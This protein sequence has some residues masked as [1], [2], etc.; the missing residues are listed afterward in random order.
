M[1]LVLLIVVAFPPQRTP[2]PPLLAP[3]HLHTALLRFRS[4]L[5][6][7]SRFHTPSISLHLK[8]TRAS[9]LTL[10]VHSTFHH[11]HAHSIYTYA[12]KFHTHCICSTLESIST[13]HILFTY[14]NIHFYPITMHQVLAP[15]YIA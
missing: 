14:F 6:R 9:S 8:K 12:L 7:I 13:C 10:R 15:N 4:L 11:T 3:I 2:P 1:F 5:R